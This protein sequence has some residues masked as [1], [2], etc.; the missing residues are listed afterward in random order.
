MLALMVVLCVPEV[1]FSVD[2]EHLEHRDG[3]F[4]GAPDPD[5]GE[6]WTSRFTVGGSTSRD[7]VNLRT[8]DGTVPLVTG[9]QTVSVGASLNVRGWMRAGVIVPMHSLQGPR[10]A[11][12]LGQSKLFGVLPVAQGPRGHSAVLV[13]IEPGLW[14]TP[15]LVGQVS[16][17]MGAVGEMSWGPW[18]WQGVARLRLQGVEALPGVRWGARLEGL[19]GARFQPGK[20]GG[21]L[22]VHASTPAVPVPLRVP[23]V[24]VEVMGFAR[25]EWTGF[26]VIAGA[27]KGA[28]QGLGTPATRVFATLQMRPSRRPR[29]KADPV[30]RWTIDVTSTA[31]LEQIW[32]AID[33]VGDW[34]LDDRLAVEVPPGQHALQVMAPGHRAHQSRVQVADGRHRT[35]VTLE[36]VVLGSLRIRL[37]DEAGAS[38][39]GV[40]RVAGEDHEVPASGSRLNLD[41]GSHSLAARAPGAESVLVAVEIRE[42]LETD[43]VLVLSSAPVRVETDA[44]EID[45]TVFFALDSAEIAAQGEAWLDRLAD[46]LNRH[47]EIELVRVEGH[48]DDLGDSRYN[49]GLSVERAERVVEA[50]VARKVNPERLQSVGSGE[51]GQPTRQV[52]FR[53]LVWNDDEQTG[54]QGTPLASGG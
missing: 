33:G 46:F 39:V 22:T 37:V 27:G 7:P 5:I 48:A 2:V 31:D 29:V 21:G 12:G 43:R 16:S 20:F 18:S 47:P 30:A 34:H 10:T 51:S 15:F 54:W 26:A 52:D 14:E 41:V 3:G 19:T 45:E 36:P 23:E 42:G 49:L 32:V 53:V 13:G 8:E 35:V 4:P 50:L 11:T 25:V 24:P 1:A 9:L 38:L 44:A 28:P 40:I 6:A 17:R